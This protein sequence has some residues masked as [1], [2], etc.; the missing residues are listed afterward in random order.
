MCLLVFKRIVVFNSPSN[1]WEAV[2]V[3]HF[4]PNS[5]F[6]KQISVY[7][8]STCIIEETP[9][10]FY[11]CHQLTHK[12]ASAPPV[13]ILQS[14]NVKWKARAQNVTLL[15]CQIDSSGFLGGPKHFQESVACKYK[16]WCGCLG[17]FMIFWNQPKSCTPST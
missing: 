12:S 6:K 15:D 10:K 3:D 8:W 9:N 4:V 16:T 14:R 11:I 13:S 7:F 1:Y 5:W 17:L 2:K